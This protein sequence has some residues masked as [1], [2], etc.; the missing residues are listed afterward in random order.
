MWRL[1]LSHACRYR[2]RLLDLLCIPSV[3]AL[4]KKFLRLVTKAEEHGASLEEIFRFFDKNKD[5]TI[6]I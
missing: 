2:D 4:E 5:G 3:Q 1:L 6:S